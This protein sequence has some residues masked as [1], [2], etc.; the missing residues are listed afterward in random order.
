MKTTNNLNILISNALLV[1]SLILLVTLTKNSYYSLQDNLEERNMVTIEQTNL[2]EKI[3]KYREIKKVLES[4]EENETEKYDINFNEWEFINY[5][6]SISVK[7]GSWIRILNMFLDKGSISSDGFKKARVSMR[8][9]ANSVDKVMNFISQINSSKDYKLLTTSLNVPE[10]SQK[11][12][13]ELEIPV[14]VIYK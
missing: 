13:F 1:V 2:E 3:K 11:G 8:V 6:Y 4:E 10:D 14:T 12:A 9:K 7:E 5:F